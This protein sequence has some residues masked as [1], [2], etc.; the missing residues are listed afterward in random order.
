MKTNSFWSYQ[1]STPTP[2]VSDLPDAALLGTQEQFEQLSPGMRREI[3]RT[4][5][6][7]KKSNPQQKFPW[8]A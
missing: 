5:Q 3:L 6:K 1:S 2:H 8:E 4:A 7:K